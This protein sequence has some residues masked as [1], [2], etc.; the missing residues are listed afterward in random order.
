MF[1]EGA[2]QLGIYDFEQQG[3]RQFDYKT[4]HKALH[5]GN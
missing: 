4:C 3:F 5:G 2:K 1:S